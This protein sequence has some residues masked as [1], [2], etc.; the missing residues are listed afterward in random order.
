MTGTE[1]AISLPHQSQTKIAQRVGTPRPFLRTRPHSSLSYP[2]RSYRA[3]IALL[4]HFGRPRRYRKMIRYFL[5]FGITGGL[6]CGGC[7]TMSYQNAKDAARRRGT[8]QNTEIVPSRH[9]TLGLVARI[10]FSVLLLQSGR[11]PNA[12]VRRSRHDVSS[13]PYALH[14]L[15][16][17]WDSKAR[18]PNLCRRDAAAGSL[19]KHLRIPRAQSQ[20]PFQPLKAARPR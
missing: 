1:A 17:I 5:S 20:T 19:R 14:A 4:L 16:N 11:L 3:E 8:T 13:A 9:T 10:C 6:G 7:A 12:Q 2:A 15:A 18:T